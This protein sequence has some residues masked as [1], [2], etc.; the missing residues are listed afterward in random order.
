MW[1]IIFAAAVV[2]CFLCIGRTRRDVP[3]PPPRLVG[4]G[5]Y[6]VEIVGDGSYLASFEKICGRRTA[7]CLN[8]KTHAHLTL[9]DDN[10]FDRQ[11]VRVSIE[12]LTVGYLPRAAA[13]E[14]RHA[15]VGVGLGGATVFECAAH[16]RGAWDAG[17]RKQ[18]NYGVW[19]DLPKSEGMEC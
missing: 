14:L 3:P 6:A 9:E 7:D 10:R 4:N 17:R 18:G 1:L 13:R 11:A 12:G 5:A 2:L 8:R 15:A 19:L 16:I